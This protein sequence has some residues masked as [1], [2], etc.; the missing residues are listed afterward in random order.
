MHVEAVPILV[1]AFAN[2]GAGGALGIT[3]HTILNKLT[4]G[5]EK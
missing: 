3:L 1:S 4:K 2:A 5:E